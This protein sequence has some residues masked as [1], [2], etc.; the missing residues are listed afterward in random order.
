MATYFAD[1]AFWIALSS[2][3]DQYHSQ[4]VAWHSAVT[5][6]GSRIVTTEAVLWEWLNALAA[7]ATRA[8]AAE[9]YRRVRA[10]KGVEVVPFDP[11]LNAAAVELYRSR[12]DK[13]WSLTEASP[14]R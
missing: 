5:R 2:R 1:T 8:T 9:G 12:G 14:K 11:D 3:R 13:D 10:D 7:T 6:T 4:A